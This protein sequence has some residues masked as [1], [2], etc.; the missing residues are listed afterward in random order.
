M[1]KTLLIGNLGADPVLRNTSDDTPVCT[2]PLATTERWKDSTGQKQEKTEWHRIVAWDELAHI[3]AEYLK[4]GARVYI[5]G[6]NRTRKWH[7][8]G[9]VERFVTEVIAREVEILAKAREGAPEKSGNHP[10]QFPPD[11][12]D[13]PL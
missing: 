9:D 13:V 11:I 1:Q 2:F 8:Q 5:E 7:G 12:F 10:A 3:C 6:K 4:K